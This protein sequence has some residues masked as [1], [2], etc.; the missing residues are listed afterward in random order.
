MNADWNPKIS[1][2][3]HVHKE[4][5]ISATKIGMELVTCKEGSSE[6]DRCQITE[7]IAIEVAISE[8]EEAITWIARGWDGIDEYDHDVF[9]RYYLD[10][11]LDSYTQRHALPPHIMIRL[12][13]ADENFKAVTHPSN[14][15]VWRNDEFQNPEKYWYF[16]RWQPD[17]PY[18]RAIV[19]D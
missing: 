2:L 13:V 18:L 19:N 1:G 6:Q 12:N 10:T 5:F 7:L 9:Y 16:Y 11:L 8:W 3:M 15:C 17:C 14:R 4:G